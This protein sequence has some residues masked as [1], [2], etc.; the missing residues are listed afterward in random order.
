MS[1]EQI[2]GIKFFNGEV[3]R[4][5][6]LISEGGGF[7]VAPSGTCFARLRLDEAYREAMTNADIAIPDSG[8]MVLLW[9]LL[10]GRK[11]RRISGWKYL[12]CLSAR[13][14]TDKRGDVLWVIPSE[15][16]RERTARWLAENRFP[17][18]DDDFY[19]APIY[20]AKID[21][22]RLLEKIENRRPRHVIVGIGSGPQEKLGYYLREH[23]N[24]RAAIHCIG[25]ALGFLVGEQVKI[26]AWADRFYLGW[27]FRLLTDPRRFLPR[28]FRATELPWLIFR[29]REKLPPLAPK[30]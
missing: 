6:D 25:A 9:M 19:V 29:Y 8:A 26:P 11:L 2:L 3:E 30:N 5:I 12:R 20:G 17:F 21:D 10:R 14:F 16:M 24:Y 1:T 27:L 28:L 7:L 22:L 4:A 23:S 13:F 18:S 15:R